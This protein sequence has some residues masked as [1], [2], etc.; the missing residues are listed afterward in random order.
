MLS[1]FFS[2]VSVSSVPYHAVGEL[3]PIAINSRE[4]GG[5]EEILCTRPTKWN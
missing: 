5:M 2:V 1:V 4:S 3:S